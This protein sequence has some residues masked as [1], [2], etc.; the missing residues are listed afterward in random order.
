MLPSGDPWEEAEV[1]PGRVLLAVLSG[2]LCMVAAPPAQAA[3][4]RI[5]E[6]PIHTAFSLPYGVASGPDGKVWFIEFSGNKIGALRP[7]AA[8]PRLAVPA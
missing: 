1:R 4:Q 5:T 3:G 7:S 8:R 6:Y 2:V